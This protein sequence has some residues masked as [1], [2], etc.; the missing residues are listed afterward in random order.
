M[1]EFLTLVRRWPWL[2]GVLIFLICGL[3]YIDLPGLYMDAVNPDYLAAHALHPGL[4]NPRFLLPGNVRHTFL[5]NYYHGVQNYYVLEPLLAFFGS[6][7]FTIR[8]AQMLFGCI[9]ISAAVLLVGKLTR[10]P[11]LA[12][13]AGIGIATDIAFIASFRDQNYIVLGGLAWLLVAVNLALPSNEQA[14]SS[15]RRLFFSGAFSGLAAYGYFVNL[16]FLPAVVLMIFSNAQNRLRGL[17]LWTAGLP[18]GAILYIVGYVRMYLALGGLQGMITSMSAGLQSLDPIQSQSLYERLSHVYSFAHLAVSND[19]NSFMVLGQF[20]GSHWGNAKFFVLLVALGILL[21]WHGA[22]WLQKRRLND[23][24]WAVLL[25]LSFASVA[26]IF[27][28]RLG[29][30]HFSVMIVF[31]YIA[32]FV[33]LS[34]CMEHSG[35]LRDKKFL[36]N[37]MVVVVALALVGANFLQQSTFFRRLNDTGGVFRSS[38]ALTIMAQEALVDRGSAV[39]D[40]PEWGFFT[41]FAL[42]TENQVPYL[43]DDGVKAIH[44]AHD[45]YPNY[46]QLRLVYWS[47]GSSTQYVQKLQEAGLKDIRKEVFKQRDGKVAFYMLTAHF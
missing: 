9:V 29:A 14:C 33:L 30:H 22:D 15:P 45:R 5:G 23:A 1:K 20:M 17:L 43:I 4:D 25:P 21:V 7:I 41:S 11:T 28:A 12:I 47:D 16:F 36:M 13:A 37:S 44:D 8:L 2:P 46:D 18:I 35:F 31:A 42:L 38:S 6:T 19:E 26:L 39:Y 27:G 3:R 32:L 34:R 24:I 40:F 10:V